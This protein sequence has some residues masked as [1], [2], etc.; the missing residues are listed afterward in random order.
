MKQKQKRQ[1]QISYF[2]KFIEEHKTSK[3][4]TEWTDFVWISDE[5]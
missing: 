2:S 4:C 3:F 1:K 5:I